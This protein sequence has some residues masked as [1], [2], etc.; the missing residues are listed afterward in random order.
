MLNSPS[1]F[2]SVMHR[3]ALHLPLGAGE[4]LSQ[5]FEVIVLWVLGLSPRPYCE[6]LGDTGCI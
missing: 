6:L 4:L 3:A 5:G 2:D 1:V